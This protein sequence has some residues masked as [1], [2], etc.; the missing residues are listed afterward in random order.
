M[1]PGMT[2]CNGGVGPDHFDALTAVI[3]WVEKGPAPNKLI[4]SQFP[5]HQ[6]SGPSLRRRPLCPYPQIAQYSG[7]GSTDD[8]TNF[9]CVAPAK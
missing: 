7:T 1:V 2:H 8:E 6:E 3:D 5:A 9:S 4:A